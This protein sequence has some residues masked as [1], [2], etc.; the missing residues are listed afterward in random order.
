MRSM[1]Y[2]DMVIP[3]SGCKCLTFYQ[4]AGGGIST[5]RPS[6]C[7]KVFFIQEGSYWAVYNS[8]LSLL[9]L[10]GAFT[11]R[12]EKQSSSQMKIA[13]WTKEV[14]KKFVHVRWLFTIR[15]LVS[16][17]SFLDS[18]ISCI[19]IVNRKR[20]KQYP[21]VENLSFIEPRHRRKTKVNLLNN[22]NK[23]QSSF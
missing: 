18:F 5:E 9:W 10:L 1:P 15:S 20:R 13:R 21:L 16:L 23:H 14:R 3:R 12:Q 19:R 8:F 7:P 17:T 11:L 6:C 22:F 2:Q 4:Q